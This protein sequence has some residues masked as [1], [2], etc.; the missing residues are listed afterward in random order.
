MFCSSDMINSESK[1]KNLCLKE[2]AQKKARFGRCR[3]RIRMLPGV[4]ENE[5]F[6]SRNEV[7]FLE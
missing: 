4:S 7:G 5:W 2:G 3:K 1:D 6:L